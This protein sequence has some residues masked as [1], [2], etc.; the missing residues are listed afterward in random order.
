[1]GVTRE[2]AWAL[3][4]EYTTGESLRKHA[5]AVEAA[6]RHHAARLGEDVEVW[7]AVGLVHDFDY[8]RWPTAADHPARGMEILRE[9]GWP[10]D[11]VEAVGSHA[12][13]TGIPRNTPLRKALFAVDE[14]CGFLMAVAYV[15]PTRSLADVEVASVRKK[16]KD[17]AF[18]RAVSRDD[19]VR[20][21]EEFGLTLEESIEH[22]LWALRGA[23][24]ALGL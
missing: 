1:M 11:V 9:R 12:A 7:G 13:Y 3:L 20:G 16:M 24:P 5:L 14:L 19:I 8:E 22:C 17:K 21:A 2:D 23:A 4:T 10:E 18:A 6:M 15:R